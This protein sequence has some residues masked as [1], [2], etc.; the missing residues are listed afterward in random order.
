VALA[1]VGSALASQFA[2]VGLHL[3]QA[4]GHGIEVPGQA[5]RLRHAVAGQTHIELALTRPRQTREQF[6]QH[7]QAAARISRCTSALPWR[8]SRAVPSSAT[9]AKNSVI[10]RLI[11]HSAVMLT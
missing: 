7:A 5:A 3:L 10:Q 6:V 2:I 1:L 4:A 8:S 11:R 9:R